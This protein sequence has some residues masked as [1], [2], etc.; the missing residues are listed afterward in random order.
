MT[1][2]AAPAARRTTAH[3]HRQLAK[4]LDWPLVRVD[5]A[6][7]LGVLP[8]HDLKTLRWKAA[9][10]GDLV[11]RRQELAAALDEG[12][13]L[14]EPEMMALLG[15]EYG[16]WRRGRDHDGPADLDTVLQAIAMD[17]RPDLAAAVAQ[18]LLIHLGAEH[19]YTVVPNQPPP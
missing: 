1:A 2:E 8:P 10:V 4:A 14:T 9:T 13:L 6:V 3:D 17:E 11:E 19:A 12:A 18:A 16:D 7:A 5:K 15:L